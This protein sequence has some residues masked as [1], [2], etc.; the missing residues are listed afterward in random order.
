MQKLRHLRKVSGF[1]QAGLAKKSG[2]SRST[3]IDIEKGRVSPRLDQ[4]SAI[5]NAL[6]HSPSV[7]FEQDRDRAEAFSRLEKA[8][9]SLSEAIASLANGT[10]SAS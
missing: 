1:T 9:E 4:M 8:V 10:T 2:V 3:I 5:A 7:F 6:G